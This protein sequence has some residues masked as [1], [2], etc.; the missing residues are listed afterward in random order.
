MSFFELNGY[1]FKRT[2]HENKQSVVA[3]AGLPHGHGPT[4]RVT[5]PLQKGATQLQEENELINGYLAIPGS[6]VVNAI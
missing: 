2:L 4:A 1:V 6:S 3:A 5:K